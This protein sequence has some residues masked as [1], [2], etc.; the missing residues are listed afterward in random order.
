M[1][2]KLQF[3]KLKK[4]DKLLAVLKSL[5]LTEKDFLDSGCTATVF[6]KNNQAVKV[7]RKTIRYFE[8][9][10]G[11]AQSFKNHINRLGHIFLPVNEILY[12]DDDF[13]IYTQDLCQPLEKEIINKK[14]TIEFFQLFKSMIKEKCMVSGLSPGNLCSYRGQILIYDYHGLHPLKSLNSGRIARNLTK[15]MTL[16]FCPQKHHHHKAILTEFNK[17]TVDQLTKLPSTFIDLLKAMLNDNLSSTEIIQL[18]DRC[19]QQIAS[20]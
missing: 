3:S 8:N 5:G 19:L 18:I 1:K 6:K 10:T 7:C 9:Y 11:N 14:I 15:Y 13:F 12:E 2:D 4:T 20:K 17:K 16:T